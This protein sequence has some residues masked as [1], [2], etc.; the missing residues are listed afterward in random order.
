MSN[1]SIGVSICVFFCIAIMSIGC[2]KGCTGCHNYGYNNTIQAYTSQICTNN[3]C[4]C[5]NGLEGDS[6]QI[7]SVLKYIQPSTNWMVSDPCSGNPSYSVYITT[8]YPGSYNVFFIN[9]LFNSGAQVTV[10]LVSAPNNQGTYLNVPSQT[11]GA[12]IVSGQGT[13][14]VVSGLGRVILNLDYNAN[15]I[16]QNCTVTMYQQL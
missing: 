1:R 14:S 15:G 4:T 2:K 11:I 9:N 6:C 7:Y 16:D 8:N 5:P 13:Y 10:Q 12:I 3:F